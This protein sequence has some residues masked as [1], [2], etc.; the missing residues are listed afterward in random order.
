MDGPNQG[1]QL[2]SFPAPRAITNH[3]GVTT[4]TNVTTRIGD[5][6]EQGTSHAAMPPSAI[7]ASMRN[8]S[9]ISPGPST[10]RSWH[11]RVWPSTDVAGASASGSPRGATLHPCFS[12]SRSCL[13][14]ACSAAVARLS[15]TEP[16]VQAAREAGPAP[17]HWPAWL[18]TG[19]PAPSTRESSAQVC[20]STSR[21]YSLWCGKSKLHAGSE[22]GSPANSE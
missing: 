9:N 21:Q 5:F 20:G 1:W 11:G 6:H 22:R 12:G 16:P 13:S 7:V 8:R 19:R 14:S 18:R 2:A 15:S 4:V 17:R 3:A 10:G